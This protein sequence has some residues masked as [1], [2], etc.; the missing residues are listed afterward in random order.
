[1]TITTE[2]LTLVATLSG[3]VATIWKISQMISAIERR[4][5]KIDHEQEI[6]E[7]TLNG[8]RERM[9][10]ISTRLVNTQA[11]QESKIA[12]VTSWLAKN[13]AFEPRRPP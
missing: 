5:D 10:H 3:F 6:L 12:E 9:E 13:T 11:N 4:I 2:L 7:L 1:M 8:V